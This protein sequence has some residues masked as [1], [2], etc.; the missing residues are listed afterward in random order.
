MPFHACGVEVAGE[1]FGQVG[2][3]FGDDGVDLR[4]GGAGISGA[5]IKFAGINSKALELCVL[6]NR[7]ND[8]SL[9]HV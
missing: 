4:E 9:A 1:R 2:I 7:G 6:K 8:K 3:F 5:Y